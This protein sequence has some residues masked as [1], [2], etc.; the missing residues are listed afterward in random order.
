MNKKYTQT[1]WVVAIPVVSMTWNKVVA[2]AASLPVVPR[3][4][5]ISGG[6]GITGEGRM[7]P[8]KVHPHVNLRECLMSTSSRFVDFDT[9]AAAADL[10]AER[11]RA[12]FAK[13]KAFLA[14]PD[15]NL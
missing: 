1:T 9:V 12:I 7:S 8:D 4:T 6:P 13:R 11:A 15:A 3:L 2:I 14:H 5:R 10:V